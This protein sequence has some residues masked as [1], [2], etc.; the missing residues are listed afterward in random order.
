M[1]QMH[2]LRLELIKWLADETNEETLA[3]IDAI[4]RKRAGMSVELPPEAEAEL[5]AAIRESESGEGVPSDQMIEHIKT[6][7]PEYENL[8]AIKGVQELFQNP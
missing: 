8:L 6:N 1:T 3:L 2:D 5:E 4:R 7:H